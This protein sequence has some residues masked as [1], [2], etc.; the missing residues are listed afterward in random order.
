MLSS[1]RKACAF[2]TRGAADAVKAFDQVIAAQGSSSEANPAVVKAHTYKG[3][4][5]VGLG[6]EEPAKL[7]FRFAFALDPTLRLAKEE[8][9]DRVIRVFEAARAGK[10]KSVLE[11]PNETA[12]KAG[13]GAGAVMAIVG[14]V[15]LAGGAAAVAL[16]GEDPPASSTD[17]SM[18][19]E[20]STPPAGSTI[21][22]AQ[23]LQGSIE[24]PPRIGVVVSSRVSVA[25]GYLSATLRSGATGCL[26][27]S[28]G[29]AA[30]PAGGS[31]AYPV[32]WWRAPLP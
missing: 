1:S 18:R 5:L 12:K 13:L 28:S 26:S 8:F 9:P 17:I 10:T 16:T 19:L 3:A 11:R 30:I 20:G 14:G 15:V 32:G 6:Q 27:G 24:S 2:I 23:A 29:A 22:L 4:A 25:S 7:S 31:N 21:S